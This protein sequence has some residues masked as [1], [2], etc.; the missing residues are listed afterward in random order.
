MRPLGRSN[1][2]EAAFLEP[3]LSYLDRKRPGREISPLL[4][5]FK[6]IMVRREGNVKPAK[7]A[8]KRKSVDA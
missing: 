4:G 8:W 7:R 6:T 1:L 2:P 3:C 5:L